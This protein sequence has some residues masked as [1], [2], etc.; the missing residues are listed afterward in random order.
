VD[1][2]A[3][4]KGHLGQTREV[5]T[6]Q[7]AFF[8]AARFL[9]RTRRAFLSAARRFSRVAGSVIRFLGLFAAVGRFL[10]G[11]EATL[12]RLAPERLDDAAVARDTLGL[13]PRLE[14]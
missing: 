7:P 1:H 4:A 13:C 8:A 10:E 2:S 9:A 14:T 12:L 3:R 6:S 5:L 11:R